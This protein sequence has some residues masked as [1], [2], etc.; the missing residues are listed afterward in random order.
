[1]ETRA[2]SQGWSSPQWADYVVVH[3]SGVNGTGGNPQE[4]LENTIMSWAAM[5]GFYGNM[6]SSMQSQVQGVIRR[7]SGQLQLGI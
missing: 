7:L 4:R 1:M 2:L 5:L 6:T 3:A